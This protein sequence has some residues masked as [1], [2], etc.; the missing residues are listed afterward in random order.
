MNGHYGTG[1]IVLRNWTLVKLIGEGSYGKVYEAAREDFGTTYKAAIK[2]IT[3]PQSQS[4]VKNARAE[5]MD[6]M[7]VTAYFRG[8]VEEIVHELVLM[9]KL[10]GNSNIV[11]YEDHV[12]VEHQGE[13]GWDVI[14]R[15]ELLT[16]LLDYVQ[17][18]TPHQEDV[19]QLGIDMCKALELCEKH[20]IVHRDIKPENIFVSEL[21]DYKLGDFGIARTI[22]KTTGGLSKKGTY[23][24]MAPEVYKDEPYNSTVDIYSLG[25]V[26]YRLLNNNRAPFLPDYPAPITHSSREDALAKRISGAEISE[27]KN[28]GKQLSAVILR[29]C[30]Y[31]AKERYA[32]AA[33]MKHALESI[34]QTHVSNDAVPYQPK[35]LSGV[36]PGVTGESTEDKTESIFG[37]AAEHGKKSKNGWDKA[38]TDHS[39]QDE[40]EFHIK[41]SNKHTNLDAD[42]LAAATKSSETVYKAAGVRSNK[43]HRK[44]GRTIASRIVGV[45]ISRKT[46]IISTIVDGKP[47]ILDSIN[48]EQY[49][50]GDD[51]LANRD[52]LKSFLDMIVQQ[53]EQT[54][55][56][57]VAGIVLVVPDYFGFSEYF[58]IYQIA[59]EA[60]VQIM[61]IIRETSAIALNVGYEHKHNGKSLIASISESAIGLADYD[62]TDDVIERLYTYAATKAGPNKS[63]I[64][65]EISNWQFGQLIARHGN[66]HGIRDTEATTLIMVGS[67]E[68]CKK[69]GK[70]IREQLALSPRDSEKRQIELK[71]AR[72]DPEVLS[73][74]AALQCGILSGDV[75]HLL[76]LDTAPGAILISGGQGIFEVIGVDATVPVTVRLP[77]G[78]NRYYSTGVSLAIYEE[79]HNNS[80][81]KIGSIKLPQIEVTDG[82]SSMI[83]TEISIDASNH[84]SLNYINS[85]TG[86]SKSIGLAKRFQNRQE[87]PSKG[88]ITFESD[89][90]KTI[91]Q[92]LPIVDSLEYGVKF[93]DK[94]DQNPHAQGIIKIYN[95]A[96]QVLQQMGVTEI[97]AVGRPFDCNLCNAVSHVVDLDYPANVVKEVVQTGYMYNGKVL[98][99]ASVIVAN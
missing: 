3:I 83:E 87:L 5:G 8:F 15:M 75:K 70:I 44:I 88:E 20:H 38:V 96:K 78:I 84:I 98:R 66:N 52:S 76:P 6:D 58:S 2:I 79:N 43:K 41:F 55:H 29:A 93:I 35:K 14:I 21:G 73:Y 23:T 49:I 39:L 12:V 25:I 53:L 4:E 37:Q 40:N 99:H 36:L 16:P 51:I 1:D 42:H 7:S 9:S 68:S 46:A 92:I 34:S 54:H 81:H 28:A 33:Q 11:S 69:Y 30:A 62:F 22:E 17:E 77:R 94:N 18:K 59:K 80:I 26:M 13:I 89:T 61:R 48:I 47:V 19:I 64:S 63:G 27:P 32:N 57:A 82:R 56:I 95:Q 67:P 60:N 90:S 31:R 91:E 65:E 10:K 74:G 24:Y 50:N 72:L 45:N 85:S 97:E 71:V 86:K